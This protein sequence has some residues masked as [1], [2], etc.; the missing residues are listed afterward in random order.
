MQTLILS[1]VI[2]LSYVWP[3]FTIMTRAISYLLTT[4]GHSYFTCVEHIG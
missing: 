2:E 3:V 1:P 4:F